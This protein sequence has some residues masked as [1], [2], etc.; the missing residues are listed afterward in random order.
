MTMRIA[1]VGVILGLYLLLNSGFMQVRIPPIAGGGIPIGE[2]ILLIVL[3]SLDYKNLIPQLSKA[4]FLLP[5]LVWWGF[6]LGRAIFGVPEWGLWALRDATH[7]IES[8]FFIVG[9]ALVIGMKKPEQL[10][11]YVPVFL[12]IVSLYALGYPIRDKLLLMSPTIVAG[13]G[14]IAPILFYY[15][16]TPQMLLWT[17]VFLLLF[18]SGVGKNI[19]I[20]N[21]L[22]GILTCYVVFLFQARTIYLQLIALIALL[23]FFRKN[24]LSRFVI[25]GVAAFFLLMLVSGLDIKITGRL[26]QAISI[27]FLLKH[28]ISTFGIATSGL[29]G[30]AHGIEQRLGWWLAIIDEWLA[31]VWNFLFGVGYGFPLTEFRIRYQVP[32]REPHNSYISIIGRLGAVG[33]LAFSWMHFLLIRIWRRTYQMCK[34]INWQTGLNWLLFIMA[35][36]VMTWVLAIGEDAFEKPFWTIPYYF[37]WG[38]I[39]AFYDRL[40]SGWLPREVLPATSQSTQNN[41]VTDE[42]TTNP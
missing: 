40:R 9:F 21:I 12:I 20:A 6:G 42:N 10:Y 31:S 22:A 8:L 17:A 36:F 23:V 18:R 1:L 33:L 4:V 29:E 35:F 13:A 27:E 5:F 38:C 24:L 2:L 39:L 32:V 25:G 15:T 30:P 3:A 11:W 14:Y 28:L 19:T 34:Q 16:N 37:F 26:Q 41:L 7:V